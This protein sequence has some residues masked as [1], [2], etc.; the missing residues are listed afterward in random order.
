MLSA[1]FI[2]HV[3]WTLKFK[4][5][6]VVKNKTKDREREKNR[7]RI[8]TAIKSHRTFLSRF[9]L[10][11]SDI[12]VYMSVFVCANERASD[13]WIAKEEKVCCLHKSWSTQ[14][15]EK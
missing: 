4:N 9:A 15:I 7:I 1:K 6:F 14:Q 2:T 11:Y 10:T 13:S 5:I 12:D 3:N 8:S